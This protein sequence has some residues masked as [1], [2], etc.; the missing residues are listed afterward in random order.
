MKTIFKMNLITAA[1]ALAGCASTASTLP[2]SAE[3]TDS[4]SAVPGMILVQVDG[5][6]VQE[7]HVSAALFDEAGYKGGPPVRGQ[8]VDVTADT[9]TLK[10]EGLP[11]GEYGIKLYQDVDKNGKMNANMFGLPTEP[12]AFSNNAI[13]MMGPAKWDAAKFTVTEDGAV[14][15]I[16][17]R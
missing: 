5:F 11:A 9:V 12:Y 16:S 1:V 15:R 7:G 3:N 17:F 8:N 14:Q 10:F 4:L 13:G 2:N 6:K